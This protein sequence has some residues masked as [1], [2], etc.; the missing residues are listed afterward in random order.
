MNK[1]YLSKFRS[2]T[3][4]TSEVIW[5]LIN[6]GTISPAKEV[7]GKTFV[8]VFSDNDVDI[9]RSMQLSQFHGKIKEIPCCPEYYADTDGN[10]YSYRLKILKQLTPIP[11][12]DGYLYVSIKSP[13]SKLNSKTPR[14]HKLIAITYVDGYSEVNNTVNHIDGDKLNN[15]PCNLEWV[16]IQENINHARKNNLIKNIPCGKNHHLSKRIYVYNTNKELINVFNSQ[17]QACLEL[18]LSTTTVSRV[19]NNGDFSSLVKS[20][21]DNKKYYLANN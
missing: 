8:W 3:G 4:L 13:K 15:K 17:R 11:D 2:I 9:V 12:K 5:T 14:V 1:Y 10:I 20:K 19:I 18:G 6:K 21:Y 16:S 7:R